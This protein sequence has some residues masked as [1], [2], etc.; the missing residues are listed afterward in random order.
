MTQRER[1]LAI[2][3]GV[4]VGGAALFWVGKTAVFGPLKAADA[5]IVDART[6]QKKL[7][8]REKELKDARKDYLAKTRRTL[9]GDP[10]EA[11]LIFA[12]SLHKLLH[13]NGL[14][15]DPS[16]KATKIT[17]GSFA[18]DKYSEFY[19]VPLTITASGTMNEL[20]NFL[21]DF[22]QLPYMARLERVTLAA[23][24]A[25]ITAAVAPEHGGGTTNG[26]NGN[27]RRASVR[28]R[29]TAGRPGT[30][31]GPD[32]PELTITIKATTLV[33]PKLKDEKE[34][35]V[36]ADPNVEDAAYARLPQAKEVYAEVF[37]QSL[38]KPWQPEQKPETT[39][40]VV[41]D[42]TPKETA[43]IEEHRREVVN[44][45]SNAEHMFVRAVDA[46]AGNPLALVV[47]ETNPGALATT[48][49]NDD[50]ID[51]G[52]ILLI[53]PRGMVVRSAEAHGGHTDYFYPLGKSFAE[54]EPLSPEEHPQ[55]WHAL[56]E[57]FVNWDEV[58]TSS[59]RV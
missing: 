53:L 25:V 50:E 37:R 8:D 48:Y 44:P 14:A 6:A 22:Y 10:K 15:D 33:M 31:V 28:A 32:G 51:D 29:S 2:S 41:V 20:V 57:A 43:K 13:R 52:K 26:A 11:Q 58:A 40:A 4:A 5:A 49:H 55:I 17:P 35:A 38:F 16:S 36:I 56:E 34:Y 7:R 21:C 54:R 39:P 30:Q 47:D 59:G 46:L 24:P 12:D 18:Y 27:T 42:T 23:D 19:E 45:R 9:H 1:I 3:M